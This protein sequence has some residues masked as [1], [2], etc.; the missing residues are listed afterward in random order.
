[1]PEIRRPEVLEAIRSVRER[2]LRVRRDQV[3][4]LDP[5]KRLLCAVLY[6]HERG[7]LRLTELHDRA[8]GAQRWRPRVAAPQLTVAQ[9]KAVHARAVG[10][11]MGSFLVASEAGRQA[12]AESL[13]QHVLEV[14]STRGLEGPLLT[15][16]TATL[17]SRRP[18]HERVRD[19]LTSLGFERGVNAGAGGVGFLDV[20][21][22]SFGFVGEDALTGS[23]EILDAVV[24]RPGEDPPPFLGGGSGKSNDP[25]LAGMDRE[26]GEGA[27]YAA[28]W[29]AS[30]V[31]KLYQEQAAKMVE[32]VA[33]D[34]DIL[35]VQV[36]LALIYTAAKYD[37]E[38][39]ML[40]ALYADLMEERANGELAPP[41]DA[42]GGTE[43]EAK[44]DDADDSE[45]DS[46][47]GEDSKDGEDKPVD[48]ADDADEADDAEKPDEDDDTQPNP[49]GDDTAPVH[50][51]KYVQKLLSAHAPRTAGEGESR[52][53]WVSGDLLT[54]P[55]DLVTDPP[56]E[57]LDGTFAHPVDLEALFMSRKRP[58][59]P[60]VGS[61]SGTAPAAVIAV[62]GAVRLPLLKGKDGEV[63]IPW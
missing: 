28:A 3:A 49:M 23:L 12:L 55:G 56:Q 24:G 20:R 43:D 13:A 26:P 37:V 2:D 8:T 4:R 41:E 62:E 14:G 61:I 32:K 7:W 27:A 35:V 15:A 48:K 21:D 31:I 17:D 47:G 51:L 46:D 16:L 58:I 38:G 40:D 5:S 18:G 52:S 63:K 33:D 19:A 25:A 60:K 34:T 10:A 59:N 30:S 53:F 45:D 44:D 42:E 1:M 9:A 29:V 57:T 50:D 36:A 54:K 22:S 6:S 39:M 11:A